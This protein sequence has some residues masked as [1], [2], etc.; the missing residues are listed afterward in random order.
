MQNNPELSERSSVICMATGAK[1]ASEGA[2]SFLKGEQIVILN[3]LLPQRLARL[4]EDSLDKL[5]ELSPHCVVTGMYSTSQ[6]EIAE[7]YAKKGVNVIAFWDNP[8]SYEYLPK[9]L[10]GNVEKI[11]NIATYVLC[12]TEE[13]AR[14]LNKRFSRQNTRVVGHP[15]IDSQVAEI[16]VKNTKEIEKKLPWTKDKPLM[17]YVGGYEENANAYEDSVHIFLEGVKDLGVK[18]DLLLQLHPRSDGC[19]ESKVVKQM[20]SK[21]PEFPRTYISNSREGISSFD[22]V[23]IADFVVANRSTLGFQAF[24]AGKKIAYVDVPQTRYSNVFIDQGL[25]PQF[26]VSDKFNGYL[27]NVSMQPSEDK[28]TSPIPCGG[29]ERMSRIIESL[30][31]P[32]AEE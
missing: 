24:L 17:M 20:Q 21:Y 4:S 9:D 23:A 6:A 18:F 25:A 29:K 1:L 5:S 7:L 19:F 3:D 30:S 15:T 14:D 10:V 27:K 32:S 31:H 13:I 28:K 2:F 16:L 22:A 12:P 26:T 8:S 11:V